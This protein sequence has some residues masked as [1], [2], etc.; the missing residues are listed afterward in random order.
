[1]IKDNPLIERI[2]KVRHQISKEYNHDPKRLVE[3][4]IELEK[5]H[6]ER[7]FDIAEIYREQPEKSEKSKGK[8]ETAI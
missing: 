5:R 4:Y 3:H 8:I 7:F 2:R 1:M 6:K